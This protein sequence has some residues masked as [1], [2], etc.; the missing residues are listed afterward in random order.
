MVKEE[1]K[2]KTIKFSI[3]LSIIFSISIIAIILFFTVNRDTL[4]YFA[5]TSIKYEYFVF[6]LFLQFFSWFIWGA[7]LKVLSI[8]S[9]KSYNISI[10][11]STKIVIANLFLAGITPSMAGGEPVRIYLLNK[12]GLSI[13]AATASVL[14]ER[15]LDAIFILICVPFA[16]FI[17]RDYINI[18]FIEIGLTIGIILFIVGIALFVLTLKYPK[19]TKAFLIA[20]CTKFCKLLR[21]N[22]H[23]TTIINR[24][25]FEVDN[26]YKSMKFLLSE[27]KR[28][29]I[30]AS[31]LTV[32]YWFTIFLIPSMILIGLN[33]QPFIIPSYAAQVLLIVIIMMPTT[34]GSAGV[35]EGSVAGLYSV[36]IGPSLIGIFILI[37]RFITFHINLIIGSIFQYRIFKSVTSFSI[38]SIKK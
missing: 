1:N 19:K 18:G 26:F 14:G 8:G 10:W 3:L 15:L 2:P 36:L 11:N 17:F 21:K 37:F 24:I 9:E 29:I 35:T 7:R 13:G 28:V 23:I 22:K 25:N 30:F 31:I 6:A 12:D 5:Q 4:Q 33:L 27:G 16:F 20:I 38:E 34:P 32:A